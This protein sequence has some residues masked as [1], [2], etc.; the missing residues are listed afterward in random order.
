MKQVFYLLIFALA[1]TMLFSCG[2]NEAKKALIEMEKIVETAEKNKNK[3]SKEEWKE[4]AGR[5]EENEKIANEAAESNQLGV[6][7]KMKCLALTTRWATVYGQSRMQ[8]ITP[9]VNDML[10]TLGSELEKMA[11]SLSEDSIMRQALE[12]DT[13]K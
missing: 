9:K 1:A 8:E 12:K 2:K 5:F 13:V 6:A 10:Q 3:L 11:D 7:G 4:L